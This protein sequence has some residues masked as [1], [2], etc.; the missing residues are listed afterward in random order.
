MG[1]LCSGTRYT[2]RP[3]R[4]TVVHIQPP[5]LRPEVQRQV[6]LRDN[7][8]P[9]QDDDVCPSLSNAHLRI[10]TPPLS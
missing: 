8:I 3:R 10:V 9:S 1:C 6:K 2:A 5:F 7:G 4:K